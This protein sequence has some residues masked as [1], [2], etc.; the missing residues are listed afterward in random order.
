[1]SGGHLTGAEADDAAFRA[2][3]APLA[4]TALPR[5]MAQ[6][7]ATP[8]ADR[9]PPSGRSVGVM[10]GCAVF[11]TLLA[12]GAASMAWL[13]SQGLR[14]AVV[15]DPSSGPARPLPSLVSPTPPTTANVQQS[16]VSPARIAQ[17]AVT[18]SAAPATSR[19][20]KNPLQQSNAALAEG[21]INAARLPAALP[22]ETRLAPLPVSPK[23]L[24]TATVQPSAVPPASV[25]LR[26]PTSSPAPAS[27]EVVRNLMQHG[28]VALADG[29]IIAARLHYERAALLGSAA[30][31]T[32]MGNTYDKAF[33]I[34]RGVL[35]IRADPDLAAAWYRKAAALGAGDPA[36]RENRIVGRSAP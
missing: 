13:H 17:P 3:L 27:D 21:D 34:K 4:L 2:R 36:D 29:D 23:P 1:M 15:T 8:W 28:D 30:G 18:S 12:A 7:P 19:A 5:G 11:V 16:A 25:A 24:P 32:A 9:A 6:Q 31:A 26:V 14:I 20:I 35:G 33:L 10:I 22:L